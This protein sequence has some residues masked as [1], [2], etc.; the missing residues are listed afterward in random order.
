MAGDDN[1]RASL[2]ATQAM[3]AFLTKIAPAIDLRGNAPTGI[4]AGLI[5]C[6]GVVSPVAMSR[7]LL[8][9]DAAGIV[10]PSRSLAVTRSQDVAGRRC[11]RVASVASGFRAV[12]APPAVGSSSRTVARSG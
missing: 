10:S 6:G 12:A 8:V 9:G 3:E 4:R 11:V 1:G 2:K 7:A 5:P